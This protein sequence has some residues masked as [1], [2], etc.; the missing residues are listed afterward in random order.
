MAALSSP[1]GSAAFSRSLSSAVRL[2]HRHPDPRLHGDEVAAAAEAGGSRWA[3]LIR[4]A[5]NLS[6]LALPMS[7][8]NLA[9]FAIGVVVLAAAGR[10]GPFELSCV[11][12][13][14]SIFNVTGM[15]LLM[16]FA[17]AMETL[18]GQA[19]GARNFKLVG[20]VYQRA[21]LLTSA[22]AVVIAL[23]WT[24]AEPLLLFFR[25][26]PLLARSAARYMRLTI[27]AL[28]G[29]GAFEASKRYLLAQVGRCPPRPS[30]W[31]G[32]PACSNHSC[33]PPHP[34]PP[35]PAL[36]QH[37]VL[38][39]R[40]PFLAPTP[41]HCFD[42]QGVVR[43]QSAVTLVG[44]ALAPLYSW[45]FIFR[46]DWRLDGAA[47]AV[48]AIQLTMAGLLGLYCVVRDAALRGQPHA[49]WHGWSMDALRGWPAYLRFG[50][51]SV[52]MI[53]CEWWTFEAMILM[54]GWLAQPNVTVAVMGIL[55]NTSGIIWMFVSGYAL[56]CSTRV[57][58]S[59]AMPLLATRA[60]AAPTPA[61]R[62]TWT[63][64]GIAVGLEL[65]GMVGML[66]LRNHWALLFTD[67]PEVRDLTARLLPIFV[68]SLP[69]DGAN[70][71]LQGLLRGS[72]GR[73]RARRSLGVAGLWWGLVL[74]NTVQGT[75]MATIALRFDFE[76]EARK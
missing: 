25:Q 36:L 5:R 24:Q 44:L 22:M 7:V 56:A 4:E 73:R 31:A 41:H 45:L 55:V 60:R 72:G 76:K 34:L 71:T 28:L 62:A 23:A 40:L 58:N 9:A 52:A 15:S 42:M 8:T 33:D 39:H 13:G 14:T 43:P 61:R 75:L 74:V 10:L 46:L 70:A 38:A 3:S 53:C 37:T 18:A 68:L 69:G 67:S 30:P 21:L 64:V 2:L 6:A 35:R 48:D 66:A 49:T 32:G 19:Y 63:A 57:S 11:V 54:S 27:P 20:V 51:P 16:G 26:D 12:L 1:L 29:Q 47:F 59:L 50:V 17:T 65:A